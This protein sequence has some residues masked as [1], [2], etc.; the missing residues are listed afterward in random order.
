MQVI[1]VLPGIFQLTPLRYV[2]LLLIARE[3]L[4]LID[5]GIPGSAKSILECITKLGRKPSEI[6]LILVTHNHF[7]HIGGFAELRK[8]TPAKVAVHQADLDPEHIAYPGKV[9]P[10]L[11]RSP[12]LKPFN[13][14]F[15]VKR[16]EVDIPLKG[17]EV[18]PLLGGLEVI[19]TP[20]HTPGSISLYS[21]KERLIIVGDALA[22]HRG[23]IDPP[24]K[25]TCSDYPQA[26]DAVK[27]LA[28][29]DFDT[30]CFGHGRPISGNL[31]DR[32]R[33][34]ALTGQ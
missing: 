25:R 4:A 28:S 19:H 33:E 12:V 14:Y 13:K 2:N 6:D 30:I 21:R 34:I 24:V 26:I 15:Y 11:I 8:Q 27:K 1:E 31:K 18:F 16:S 5:T 32:V 17:G 3:R 23:R 22:K 7:D 29:L 9:V 10:H 20:G